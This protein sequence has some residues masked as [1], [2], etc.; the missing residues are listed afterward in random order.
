MF[1]TSGTATL[2]LGHS[3]KYCQTLASALSP[4]KGARCCWIDRDRQISTLLR[5]DLI[6]AR[7]RPLAKP[8]S[9]SLFSPLSLLP[10]PILLFRRPFTQFLRRNYVQTFVW[11]LAKFSS[12]RS[13][14]PR[15]FNTN[16]FCLEWLIWRKRR[17]TDSG[18]RSR[19]IATCV[20]DSQESLAIAWRR[21]FLIGTWGRWMR[22]LLW[23]R[24]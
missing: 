14:V 7:R 8:P 9:E 3:G 12:G 5:Y 19:K 17:D 21:L 16:G 13:R 22:W 20:L 6:S 15:S 2:A 11:K 1:N 23:F 4:R 24:R 18:S 10:R